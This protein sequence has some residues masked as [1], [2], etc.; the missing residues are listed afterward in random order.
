MKKFEPAFPVNSQGGTEIYSGMSLRDWFAGMAMLGI[1]AGQ[2]AKNNPDF[3]WPIE[4]IADEAYK[5]ADAML[6]IKERKK[7]LNFIVQNAKKKLKQ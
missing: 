7:W 5:Q 6:K 1:V 4:D 3:V 2:F